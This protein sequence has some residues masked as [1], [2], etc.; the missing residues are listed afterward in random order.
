MQITT[1][2]AAGGGPIV[3]L[4]Y[5]PAGAGKTYLASTCGPPSETLVVATEPGLLTLRR[6]AIPVARVTTTIDLVDVY[7]LLRSGQHPYRW[8]V[9]DSLTEAAELILS[10]EKARA[11]DPRQAYGELADRI[12]KLVRAWAALPVQLVMTARQARIQDDDGRIY[13]GPAMPGKQLPQLLPHLVDEVMALRTEAL[14]DG[15]TSRW[16]Q[17][18]PDGRY[19]AKDRSGALAAREEPDLARI[20]AKIGTDLGADATQNQ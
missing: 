7:R 4:V 2:D 15:G 14:V 18:Q 5:G 12:G 6:L 19:D 20:A 1:T 3:Y 11:K 13:Y 8:V 16:L 17:T 10:E 9:L